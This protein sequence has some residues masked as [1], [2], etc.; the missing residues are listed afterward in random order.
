[1][2]KK[3][4]VIGN[5]SFLSRMRKKYML[6]RLSTRDKKVL[7][8]QQSSNKCK[9]KGLSTRNDLIDRQDYVPHNAA[10]FK[11]VKKYNSGGDFIGS[12]SYTGGIGRDGKA[13]WLDSS[14]GGRSSLFRRAVD[15]VLRPYVQA[16]G[17]EG[18]YFSAGRFAERF[19][20]DKGQR[21]I[22]D[23]ALEATQMDIRD[24]T[25]EERIKLAN[26]RG[27]QGYLKRTKDNPKMTFEEWKEKTEKEVDEYI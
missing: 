14:G 24:L 13:A 6:L 3:M 9:T 21:R 7:R 17:A 27:Y 18:Y 16:L 5:P 22:I 23:D 12:T 1:M 25:I 20:L 2:V 15:H 19:G 10:G 11:Y 4:E 8:G 26:Q